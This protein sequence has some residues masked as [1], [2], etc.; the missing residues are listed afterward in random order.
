V[1]DGADEAEELA[2]ANNKADAQRFADKL[3]G[4]V[5][6]VVDQRGYVVVQDSGRDD[7]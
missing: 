4:R 7:A 2:F 1:T 5:L 3:G 6:R